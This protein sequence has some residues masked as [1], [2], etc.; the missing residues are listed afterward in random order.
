MGDEIEIKP[1]SEQTLAEASKLTLDVFHL[2][3]DDED[4]PP[5]SLKASLYPK[6]NKDYYEDLDVTNL[7][8][9]VAVDSNNHVLGI[10]GY[11]TLKYDE[12]EAYWVGWYCVNPESRGKGV[13]RLLLNLI[14]NKTKD[15]GKKWLRLYT[16]P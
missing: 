9:W 12:K 5:K 10:I 3:E 15:D 1:L 6:E 8:Y 16:S 11:Y 13:G 2:H 14:I 7:K 4:Y